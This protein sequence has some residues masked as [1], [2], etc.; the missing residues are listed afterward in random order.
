MLNEYKT[1]SLA[2]FSSRLCKYQDFPQGCEIK[3]YKYKNNRMIRSDF[4]VQ[5]IEICQK[6]IDKLADSANVRDFLD[7]AGKLLITDLNKEGVELQLF[8]PNGVRVNGN[9]LLCTIRGFSPFE[10]ESIDPALNK[11]TK[12]C[13]NSGI[14]NIDSLQTKNLYESL[15]TLTKKSIISDLLNTEVE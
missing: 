1:I 6:N 10:N 7:C 14:E 5:K 15:V 2:E 3:L 8:Y 11:F 12:L 13:K 4:N 9:T